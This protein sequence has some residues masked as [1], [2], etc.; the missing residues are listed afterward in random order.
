MIYLD[1]AAT[2]YPKPRDVVEAVSDCILR[3]GGNPGRGAHAASLRAA[4]AVYDARCEV[5]D[6]LGV[7]D[8]ASIIFTPN[9]TFALNLAISCRVRCG[10]HILISDREHNAAFRPVVRLM[11]TGIADY[12]VYS[13]SGDVLANIRKKE[14]KRTSILICNPVSNVTGN[15]LPIREIAAYAKARG[16][17]LILDGAQWIGHGAPD[18]DVVG[19]ADAIAVP[20]HKALY[21]MQGS[22]FLYLK[23]AEGNAPF[24][25]G[26]S[27]SDSANPDMPET[28][29]ERYEAGTLSTPAIVSLA[30]GIRFIR[31][32]GV[33]RISEREAR[34]SN[35]ARESMSRIKGVT[36]YGNETNGSPVL[37]FRV[38]DVP[39]EE[40]ARRLDRAGI[41]VRAGLH[42]APLIHRALGTF[43]EGT[44]R[45]SFGIFNTEDDVDALVSALSKQSNI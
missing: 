33:E 41:A 3:I 32:F 1:N 44:V 39:P 4:E 36:L 6:F 14:T 31:R 12:S 20:G 9:A 15:Y 13:G 25:L 26:G 35:Y 7:S 43:P 37:S 10:D 40:T 18:R 21:G 38:K 23:S 42:C 30:A 5:A 2:T 16:F 22:G 34:L 28:L 19:L 24:L 11:E 29:P 27:G 45:A 17:Y 8:P